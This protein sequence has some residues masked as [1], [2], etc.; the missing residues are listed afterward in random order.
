MKANPT[1]V[2]RLGLRIEPRKLASK[3]L[4]TELAHRAG[5]HPSQVSR[6][7]PKKF[8]DPDFDVELS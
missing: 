8:G 7:C 4:I 2:R 3:W 6:I 1:L 5:V